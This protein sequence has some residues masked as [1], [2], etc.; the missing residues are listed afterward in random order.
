M[1]TIMQIPRKKQKKI[2]QIKLKKLKKKTSKNLL[3]PIPGIIQSAGCLALILKTV[4]R[5]KVVK[6]SL[7]G[8]L[9]MYS[10]KN[11]RKNNE[12]YFYRI[13]TS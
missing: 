5:K 2:M 11:V 1:S 13:L 7:K 8:I 4:P 6:T 12:S 3:T 9:Q 10:K